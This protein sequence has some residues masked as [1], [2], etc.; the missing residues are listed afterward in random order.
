ML[1]FKEADAGLNI[2]AELLDNLDGDEGLGLGVEGEEGL[3]LAALSDA[4]DDLEVVTAE[5]PG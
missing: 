3:A 5:D 2:E 1:L 4:S